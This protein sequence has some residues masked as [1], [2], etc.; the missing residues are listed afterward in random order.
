M[1]NFFHELNKYIDRFSIMTYDK[2][3]MTSKPNAP[4]DWIEEV[5]DS[6]IYFYSNNTNNNNTN[7]NNNN[8]NNN[9]SFHNKILLGIPLYGW[10][11][12]NAMTGDDMIIWL[13]S[14]ASS[15]N[16]K[17]TWNHE[18]KEHLFSTK[19]SKLQCYFPTPLFIIERMKL[20]AR[21]GVAG[22]SF[23]ELGQGFTMNIDLF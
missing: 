14:N 21:L 11:N 3:Q 16:M 20:A 18:V 2:N 10:R 9:E 22:V 6:F 13:V 15:N 4:Y 17:I 23:W 5:I 7:S 8:N 12:E 19:D 1:I